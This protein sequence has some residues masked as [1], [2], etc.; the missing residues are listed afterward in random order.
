MI[1]AFLP[2]G[3]WRLHDCSIYFLKVNEG[4]MIAAFTSSRWM[5]VAWL[6]HLLPQ[7]EWRLHDCSISSQGGWRLHDCSIYFLKVNEGCMIAAFL[8]QGGWRLHDCSIYFLKVNEG[9]MIA[10]FTS[11]RWM[12][13]AWLQHLLPQGGWRL[14]YCRKLFPLNLQIL[15]FKHRINIT[16]QMIN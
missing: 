13:V 9:C 6:Q 11:S 8:P 2:Q 16:H 12:K 5:K 1:A 7:G 3:G 4:C 10:A 14:Q 15:L